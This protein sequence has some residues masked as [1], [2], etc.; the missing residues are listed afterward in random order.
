VIYKAFNLS[1]SFF[2]GT[3]LW[4]TLN[5]YCYHARTFVAPITII[6]TY[7]RHAL[8]PQWVEITISGT[9]HLVRNF[10][11]NGPKITIES[12]LLHRGLQEVTLQPYHLLLPPSLN[13]VNYASI[14]VFLNPS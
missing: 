5:H 2:V 14:P 13:L 11:Q 10:I 12:D 8:A 6:G 1:L 3:L 9:S 7:A 4:L